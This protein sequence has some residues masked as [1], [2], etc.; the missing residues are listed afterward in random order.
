MVGIHKMYSFTPVNPSCQPPP[1]PIESILFSRWSTG[2]S[3]WAVCWAWIPLARQVGGLSPT[4]GVRLEILHDEIPQAVLHL[5]LQHRD[6]EISGC[7]V[8]H[9]AFLLPLTTTMWWRELYTGLTVCSWN[10]ILLQVPPFFLK[11]RF[12]LNPAWSSWDLQTISWQLVGDNKTWVDTFIHTELTVLY[13]L[14]F[15]SQQA[16]SDPE[17]LMWGVMFSEFVWGAPSWVPGW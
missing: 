7:S 11:Q 2:H 14:Y 15:W 6:G 17:E 3:W 8:V 12:I 5:T 1:P 9:T 16:G 10:L 13:F 4:A